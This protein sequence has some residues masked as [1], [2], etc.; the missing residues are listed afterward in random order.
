MANTA[1]SKNFLKEKCDKCGYPWREDWYK[2]LFNDT[3]NHPQR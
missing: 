2:I 3:V 1:T